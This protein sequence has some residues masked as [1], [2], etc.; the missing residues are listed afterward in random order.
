MTNGDTA[1]RPLDNNSIQDNGEEILPSLIGKALCLKNIRENL[2]T[3]LQFLTGGVG[4]GGRGKQRHLSL[5]GENRHV[6]KM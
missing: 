6:M 1:Q 5:M 4:R 3:W 2:H